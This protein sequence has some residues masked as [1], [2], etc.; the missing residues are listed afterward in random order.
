VLRSPGKPSI[1][2][3]NGA[4][5]LTVSLD[6]SGPH[7]APKEKARRPLGATPGEVHT[8][9]NGRLSAIAEHAW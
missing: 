6:W 5:I 1:D 2:T 3:N 9:P 7:A 8:R 4:T